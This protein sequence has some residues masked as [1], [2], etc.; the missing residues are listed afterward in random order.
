[1]L[2]VTLLCGPPGAGKSTWGETFI[3]QNNNMSYISTDKIRE[4]IGGSESNQ[5]V[6]G[7]AF[8]IAKTRM[9]KALDDGKN[10][11]ID[12]TNMYRK[13]RKDFINIA[14]GRGAQTIAVVF[15]VDKET[16][17]QRNLKRGTEGGRVVPEDVIQ[18]MLNKYE[19]PDNNEFDKVKFVK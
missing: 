17:I 19:R 4:E 14:R 9:G 1:M 5:A 6:S 8:K 18:K 7:L 15:E 16:L 10:V 3:K 13:T 12:A 2:T 11:L